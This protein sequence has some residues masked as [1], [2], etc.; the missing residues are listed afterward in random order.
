M[1]LSPLHPYVG[2]GWL[3]CEGLTGGTPFWAA[4]VHGVQ[5]A[6]GPDLLGDHTVVEGNSAPVGA[7]I[8]NDGDL[9]LNDVTVSGNTATDNGGTVRDNTAGGIFSSDEA[10]LTLNNALIQENIATNGGGIAND[11]RFELRGRRYLPIRALRQR[12][13]QLPSVH[14]PFR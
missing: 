5:S 11:G 14:L 2:S 12:S 10:S 6:V 13:R 7:G 3:P 1:E 4:H 8:A 9:T